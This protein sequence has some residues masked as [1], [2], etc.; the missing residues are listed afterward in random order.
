MS[1]DSSALEQAIDQQEAD[2]DVLS[3]NRVEDVVTVTNGNVIG[4]QE[5]ATISYLGF[6]TGWMYSPNRKVNTILTG[7][8]AGGKSLVQAAITS[9][10]PSDHAYEASDA[11]SMG[12]LD[13]DQWEQALYAPL[14]EWQKIP[15]KLTE[16]L[17]GVAG[18]ADDEYR[19]VRSVSDDEAESGRSGHTIVK[20]PRSYNFLY[21][22]HA[23]DH[24]LSTRLVFLPVD[25]NVHIRDA[26]VEKEGG[27]SGIS[28]EGYDKEFVFDTDAEEQAL[29]ENLRQLDTFIDDD[30]HRVGKVDA[31]LSPWVR[32]ATKPILDMDQTET[33]RVAGQIF[34]LIRASAVLNHENRRVE[35]EP[36]EDT[37]EELKSYIAEPQDVANVLSARRTLLAKTHHL[38]RLKRE[39]LDSI[40]ANQHFNESGDGVGVNIDTIR[41]YLD[42]SSKVP[43][44]RKQKLRDLLQ[45]LSEHF[46]VSIHERA[47]RNG[48]HLYEFR[49]LRDVGVPRVS[50]LKQIMDEG[51]IDRCHELTPHVDLDDPF[52]DARDPFREQ[53]FVD[54]VESLRDELSSN[55]VERAE[56]TAE[57]AGQAADEKESDDGPSG[58]SITLGAAM[59]DGQVDDKQPSD[60][61]A[62]LDFIESE[63][64]NRLLE[65]AHD[66]PWNASKHEESH[67]L[68]AIPREE[69]VTEADTD[70]TLLDPNH[71]LWDDP[72][73][74]DDWVVARGD[75]ERELEEA[76]STLENDGV[77]QYK[78][79][80]QPQGFVATNVMGGD[81][82]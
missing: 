82:V 81:L 72:R 68:G 25:N 20:K 64:Y 21:A 42:D 54:T 39:I 53:P 73:K 56:K 50:N 11:S 24:E 76:V 70:G 12:V 49:S 33:N 52:H 37:D 61:R 9:A 45:E 31:T 79:D 6:V 63:V 2:T 10:L 35:T 44:P 23:L 41:D 80:D 77:L 69:S 15:E 46:Y 47:G 55:P 71:E 67:M 40:R 65:N 58:Q 48:S 66:E 78:T 7:P 5:Q 17:K 75:C 30:D 38:T 22:Q 18:G 8:S 62:D 43:T 60:V 74:P 14:D 28:V 34:N 51:E 36:I 32:K 16:I 1:F 19:Y 26:I 29:R 13:D 27:A 4:N 59:D 3:D 57:L